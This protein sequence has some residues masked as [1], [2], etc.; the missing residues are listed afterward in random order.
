MGS[1]Q[2][3]ECGEVPVRVVSGEGLEAPGPWSQ[4]LPYA[5]FLCGYY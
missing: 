4:T 3:G 1:F 5:S 2:V